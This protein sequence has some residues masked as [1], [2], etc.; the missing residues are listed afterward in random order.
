LAG[1]CSPAVDRRISLLDAAGSSKRTIWWAV[2]ADGGL[3]AGMRESG[4]EGRIQAGVG[5]W[6]REELFNVARENTLHLVW[7]L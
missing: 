6:E 5:T 7:L 3:L 4:K 2:I 1:V